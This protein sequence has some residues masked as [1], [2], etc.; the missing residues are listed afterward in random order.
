MKTT[1]S[2]VILLSLVL[3]TAGPARS[4]E[5]ATEISDTYTA[6]CLVRISSDPAFLPLDFESLDALLHSSGVGGRA[7]RDVLGISPDEVHDLIQLESVQH[8]DSATLQPRP[9][10]RRTLPSEAGM[11]EYQDEMM[12]EME[13]R[14]SSAPA[15]PAPKV[16]PKPSS[17]YSRRSSSSGTR[18]GYSSRSTRTPSSAASRTAPARSPS[19][20]AEKA[21]LIRLDVYLDE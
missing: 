18:Y 4:M 3:L 11:D 17:S 8:I 20:P 13:R 12:M 5:R 1:K 2:I 9:S 14:K 6:S 10:S 7:V 16:K 21:I 19:F 15:S